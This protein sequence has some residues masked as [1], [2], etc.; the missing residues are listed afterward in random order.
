MYISKVNSNLLGDTEFK[1]LK[2]AKYPLKR[3]MDF[4]QQHA[5]NFNPFFFLIQCLRI[6]FCSQA[7]FFPH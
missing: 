6:R 4:G 5:V 3:E 1:K 2:K 7:C